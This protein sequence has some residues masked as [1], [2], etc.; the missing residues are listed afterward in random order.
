M[1]KLA[2]V[3][4]L[5]IPSAAFAQQQPDLTVLQTTLNLTRNDRNQ[6]MD[7]LTEAIARQQVILTELAKAQAKIKELEAKQAKA[8][9]KP[10]AKPEEA[11]PETKS[12]PAPESKPDPAPADKSN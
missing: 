1:K 2:L 11:K 8:E 5:A 6:V 3:L 7:A 9:A 4:A 10:E 12:E